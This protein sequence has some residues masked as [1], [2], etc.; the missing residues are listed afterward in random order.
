M[1]NIIKYNRNQSKNQTPIKNS[2]MKL[3]QAILQ[4]TKPP[5]TRNL[6]LSFFVLISSLTLQARNYYFSSSTGNDSYSSTQAQ[7]QATPWKSI[8]KL[9]S[10]FGSIVA[11]DNIYF[12]RGDTFYGT[13]VFSKS[14]TSTALITLGAYGTGA[15][16]VIS[17]LITLSSWSSVGNGVYQSYA[18]TVKNSVN[19]VTLNNVP[20]GVG[21]F[22]NS[23][24]ANAG[25]LTYDS[26]TY[27]T[28]TDNQLTGS[29]NWTGAEVVMR[30]QHY[31]MERCIVTNHTNSVITYT[32][33]TP[34]NPNSTSAAVP[35]DGINGYGYFFQ[36]DPRTLDKL[37]E[38]Y[39][40]PGTKNLQMYFGSASPGSSSIEVSTLDTLIN[41]NSRSY[42]NINNLTLEGANLLAV[43]GANGGNIT[44]QSC[45]INYGGGKGI[46]LWNEPNILIEGVNT[47]NIL[48]TGIDVSGKNQPNV[49]VRN[50]NVKNTG[51]IAGM[52]SFWD[53]TDHKGI[54]VSVS[55]DALVEYNNVEN[56]GYVGIQFQG[57]NV[58]VKNNFINYYDIIK[59]DGGGIY[60]YQSSASSTYRGRVIRD[61]I[62]LNGIGS[63][64]GATGTVDVDGIFLDGSTMGVDVLNNSIANIGVNGVYC[65]NPNTVNIRGNTCFNNDCGVG[66]TRYSYGVIKNL[67]I[68]QNIFYAKTPQQN[69]IEYI[70]TGL[71]LPTPLTLQQ[72]MEQV[73]DIDSNYYSLTN[74]TGFPYRYQA[75]SGGSWA[76]PKPMS[77]EK[78]RSF[79]TH[80]PAARTAPILPSYK[81][82]ALLTAN[83]VTN[84]QF[85]SNI[86]GTSVW[87]GTPNITS[88]WDNTGK[89]NGG[90]LRITPLVSSTD[91]TFL[92]GSVGAV[93]SSKKYI[94]RFTTVG[95]AAGGVLRAYIRKSASP[96]TTLVTPQTHNFGTGKTVHEFLISAPTT[97]AA[98]SFLI[99][100]QQSS[101]T[102]Y[103]DDIQFYEA[104]AT[105][106]DV[107]TQVRFEYNETKVAK[108]VTLDAQYSGTDD[109]IYNGSITLQ[110]YT[111]KIL[112]KH[113]AIV[114][115]PPSTFTTTATSPAIN[116]FGGSANVTVSAAG[117]TAPYTGTGTFAVTAGKG[118]LKITA[119]NPS[120]S[121]S[122]L[123]YGAVGA[124]SSSKTYVLKFSTL[125]NI[126]NG[127]LSAYLRLTASP[128][129]TITG[130]QSKAFG[131]NKT[132]HQ[133]IFT[134]PTTT[135][136]A[137]FLIDLKQNADTVYINN[138]GFFEATTAGV[139]TSANLFSNPNM[140]AGIDGISTWSLDNSQKAEWDITGKIPNTYYYTVK[141]N[142]GAISTAAAVL[143]QP[144]AA[145]NASATAAAISS[146]GGT[147][148][149]VVNAT[150][151]TPPYTGTGSFA[152]IKAGT[153][154]YTVTDAKGCTDVVT[155]TVTQPV[156][157]FTATASSN[158]IN[159]FGGT[160][161]VVVSA[162]GGKA[163]Y[164]G[165]G[166]F[167]EDAGKGSL[168][169]LV[170]TPS[171]RASTLIYSAIGAVDSA[172]TYILR[173]STLGT[174]SNGTLKAY[175]RET[176]YPYE[177]ISAVSTD[178]FGTSRVDHE[179]TFTTTTSTS[180]A[181]F[182][183][184]LSQKSGTTYFD[185]VAFFEATSAGVLISDNLYP[186]GQ[187]ESGISGITTWSVGGTHLA[188][189]DQSSKI[190]NIYYYPIT[191]ASGAISTA[192]AIVSQ[193]SAPL[194]A[195]ISAV[196]G[197]VTV[198]PSG[199]T[200]PY[201]GVGI[202]S[203]VLPGLHVYP[204]TD[205]RG[206]KT[207]VSIVVS[208]LAGRSA[209]RTA[210]TPETAA[211]VAPEVS[212]TLSVNAYP[213]PTSTNFNLNVSGGT[214]EAVIVLVSGADGRVVYKTQGTTNKTYNFGNNI[215][216]GIYIV[217]IVQGTTVQTL[218]VIKTNN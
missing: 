38:W 36:R 5:V 106:I 155:I 52:G 118:S 71:N 88:G 180:Q 147:T 200:A 186:A 212:K 46:F 139:L 195:T 51:L 131:K 167:F 1:N 68:K 194:S 168:K 177:T 199:G 95:S 120:S 41:L 18:P 108:T 55:T 148:T 138:I 75:V 179:F 182:L 31:S 42:I 184:D 142:T 35:I 11:G 81:L 206:C 62:V 94:L 60:T 6:I 218:K 2:S 164:T 157:A 27:N 73:G 54:Y 104:D 173:F 28:I 113:G 74:A 130:V 128:N 214:N 140:V 43:A 216:S 162:A 72:S 203:G 89:I 40:N 145:L 150:G 83:T 169:I 166:T 37:G 202:V 163:P 193:P 205:A 99:E 217:K 63:N 196:G 188:E 178:R 82:N 127:N 26:H 3:I 171:P 181:S 10:F 189:W 175:I 161:N 59:D 65:N 119:S 208:L 105:P 24:A 154:N 170:P 174:S 85:T 21:R 129:T 183:I 215:M 201:L 141:D 158:A 20:Q 116:C 172:K 213:N 133:F 137:S 143:N 96:Q 17:A 32:G 191:D 97:D 153:F 159:C 15:K 125:G 91:F 19:L 23:D 109:A 151:G 210:G 7:N 198:T 44:M 124:V 90:S 100:I 80:E 47:T 122:T 79:T 66:I 156:S 111:S 34:I 207:T 126:G 135:S 117:G 149:V 93:S 29:P 61:N 144:S 211:A 84:G 115:A 64:L 98:A 53:D 56:T 152:N 114:V 69:S 70:N 101:G 132:D 49:T 58:L 8:A 67:S 197:I 12:M 136:S 22:P 14:G 121:N 25:Y 4:K 50:C 165:T 16:P 57:N 110:P 187:F 209:A 87:S 13:I 185:N 45:D 112:F 190:S 176:T 204:V 30:K 192:E 9:N 39:F 107:D 160:T 78:W 48:S 102:T 134:A 92:Y 146:I 103:V 123:V 86:T 77:F 33:T 76:F